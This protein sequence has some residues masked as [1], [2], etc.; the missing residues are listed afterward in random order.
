MNA[1]PPSPDIRQFGRFHCPVAL[2]Q[3]NQNCWRNFFKKLALRSLSNSL[4]DDGVRD[5]VT[6]KTIR[7]DCNR[8]AFDPGKILAK[9]LSDVETDKGVAIS[10]R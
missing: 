9:Q 1:F 5:A 10:G 3:N 2:S 8:V 6:T 4:L 7:H